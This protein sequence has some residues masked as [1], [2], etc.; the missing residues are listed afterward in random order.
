MPMP[1]QFN[2]NHHIHFTCEGSRLKLSFTIHESHHSCIF[3]RIM[4][5]T[6]SHCLAQP[7][8]Q[9]EGSRSGE[10]LSRKRAPFA[11]ARAK[12]KETIA[13]AGSR[14]DETPL[15]WARHSLAQKLSWSPERP[16]AYQ[17]SGRVPVH[18]TQARLAR[19]GEII[20]SRHYFPATATHTSPK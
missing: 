6:Q 7:L 19:L 12:R 9:A 4:H 18:L 14:L 5:L 2:T 1:C 17:R 10:R 20:R 15:A 13:H 11:Q 3:I 8:A 16:L